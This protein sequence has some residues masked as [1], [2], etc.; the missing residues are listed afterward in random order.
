VRGD[1]AEQ[2]AGIGD[3]ARSPGDGAGPDEGFGCL[4][5]AG[6]IA[7]YYGQ[8]AQRQRPGPQRGHVP[9]R[10]GQ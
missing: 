10:Q 5:R 2:A 3:N 1:D 9:V 6:L 4:G 8:T 7:G